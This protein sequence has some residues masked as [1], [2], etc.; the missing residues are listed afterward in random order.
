MRKSDGKSFIYVLL[1]IVCIVAWTAGC[2]GGPLVDGQGTPSVTP[3]ATLQPS[4]SAQLFYPHTKTQSSEVE[5]DQTPRIPVS[6]ENVE[7]FL[8]AGLDSNYPYYGRTEAL[9]LVFLDRD[10]GMASAVSI[11][12]DL[13]VELQP[14][15]RGRLN[16]VYA[17][18]QV[19]ALSEVIERNFGITTDHY[20]IVNRDIMAAF[21]DEFGGVQIKIDDPISRKCGNL[22]PGTW[23]VDGERFV[24][25]LSLRSGPDETSRNLRQA[26]LISALFN[27]LV[28]NG[29]LTRLNALYQVY[30]GQV[31]TDINLFDLIALLPIFLRVGDTGH[32]GFYAFRQTDLKV[33]V[34]NSSTGATVLAALPGSIEALLLAAA[35]NVM[36]PVPQTDLLATFVY[37]LTQ[38]PTPTV[39]PTATRTPTRTPRPTSTP[40]PTRTPRPTSTPRPT[41]TPSPTITQS[42]TASS[43]ATYAAS[44]SQ[45]TTAATESTP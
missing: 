21:V 10:R 31:V 36:N 13:L 41:R 24:C 15:Q 26:E 23:L 2:T 8:L 40:R 29:S 33:E 12:P 43:A 28:Y 30:K 1:T 44:P 45:G 16:T 42:P 6:L 4:P 20:L 5:P 22:P 17:L 11:P 39:T 37:A 9:M 27:T 18:G 14:N 3:S 38:S 25:L 7:V 19:P 34:L 32:L 35:E